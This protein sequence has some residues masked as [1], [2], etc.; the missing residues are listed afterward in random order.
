[1]LHGMQ[2]GARGE[3][4]ACKNPFDIALQCHLVDFDERVGIGRLGGWTR[5]AGTG[6]N[7]EG[8]ELHRLAD[9]GV[10]RCC[11]AGNLVET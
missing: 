9:G 1:M 3:H 4:P 2:S 5:I 11:A 6:R 10:E 8:A 7:L